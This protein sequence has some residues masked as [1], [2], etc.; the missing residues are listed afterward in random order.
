MKRTIFAVLAVLCLGLA[1]CSRQA[2]L[3]RFEPKAESAAAKSIIDQL[4]NGDIDAVKAR[5]DPKYLTPDIDAT[6][7]ALA[8]MFPTGQPDSMRIVGARTVHFSGNGP[9]TASFDLTYEYQFHDVW[10]IADI[11]LVRQ[12]DKLE[13]EGL[14]ARRTTRSLEAGHAFTLK[15]Q[16]ATHW[17]VLLLACAEA[18]L[19]LYA[20]VSCLRAP[21]ARR[22]WLWVL[23]TLVG[24]TTLHFDWSSGHFAFQP[25]SVQLLLGVSAT[26]TPYGPWILGLSVPLGAIWFLAVRR[27][28]IA[29]SVP[30]P[31]PGTVSP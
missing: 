13:I 9:R 24:V 18:L 15:G 10:V 5:L 14:H 12:N 30:P 19:C 3:D 1:A 6:L 28:L 20:F 21:I 25:I 29:A 2:M 22:K 17:L 23:F 27:R 31:L 7:R 11:V 16:D 26:A 4:R 8:A